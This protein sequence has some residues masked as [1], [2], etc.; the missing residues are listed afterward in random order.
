MLGSFAVGKTSLVQRFVQN[1]FSEKYHTTIGVKIDKKIVGVGEQTLS[2]VL[3]DI[4]G[5][6]EFHTVRTSYLRGAS[7]YLLVVDKTRQSTLDVALEI[8]AKA[9]ETLGNVPC[10]LLINKCDLEGKWDI[11]EAAVNDLSKN[12]WEIIQTSA[13][14]GLGVEAAFTRLATLMVE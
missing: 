8:H 2:L 4:A 3:W 9:Q 5:E 14:T 10:L 12:G 13:K 6:D 7:G 11:G 1:L